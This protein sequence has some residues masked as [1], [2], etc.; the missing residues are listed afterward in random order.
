MLNHIVR[1]H[2][3]AYDAL[4][5]RCQH[6]KIGL[7]EELHLKTYCSTL[8]EAAKVV[9]VLI[10]TLLTFLHRFFLSCPVHWSWGRK[11]I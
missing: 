6:K 2:F 9:Y 10:V 7:K 8:I 1:V 5:L 11:E 3:R 4:T